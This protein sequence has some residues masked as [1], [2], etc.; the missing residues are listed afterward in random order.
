LAS[1]TL[2]AKQLSDAV[3]PSPLSPQTQGDTNELSGQFI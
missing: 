3:K 1:L 2:R